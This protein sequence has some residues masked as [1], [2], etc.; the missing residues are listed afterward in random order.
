MDVSLIIMWT[1]FILAGY[2]VVGNDSIQTLGTFLSSNEDK[3]WY[4]LWAFAGSILAVTLL[5]G[6]SEYDGDVSYGRLES[7]AYVEDMGWPYLLPPLVLMLLTRTGIPVSTSFLILTF[8]KPAGLF[9]MTMKS[10]LGYALAF[11][12]AIIVWQL[13]TRWLDKRFINTEMSQSSLRTW[14]ILQWASTGFLWGQWLIQDFANIFVYLPR[15]L[16]LSEIIISLVILL[17]MLAIIFYSKGGNIQKIVK[18]KTNTTDIRSA[19][20]IDFFYGIILLFFK[21]FSNVPMSTTWVFLGLLAG[22]EIA[23]R[24]RLELDEEPTDRGRAPVAYYLG[25]TLNVVLL[26]LIGYVVYLRDAVD[27]LVIIIMAVAMVARAAVAYYETAPGKKT[28]GAAFRNI[29]SDLGKV[30]FGLLV[31]IA[32]VYVMRYLT[33][34][35]F[36]EITGG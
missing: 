26:I 36:M 30:T 9:D 33:T 8:F 24:Y 21:E 17:T 2:A 7:Y 18:A 23:I 27:N 13:V 19:T 10:I 34:G 12:A 16:H 6:W 3:K 4:V 31:S 11:C 28:L 35:T 20:F 1:G 29:F 15:S 25:M 32:L 14:T 5:Y 22:R